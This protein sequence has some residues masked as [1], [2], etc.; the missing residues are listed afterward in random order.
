M[1]FKPPKDNSAEIARR[2]EAQRQAAIT[3]GRQKID[4]AFSQ[5]ND[6][7]YQGVQDA[8]LGYYQP[9]LEDQYAK[10]RRQLTLALSRSGNLNAS[11][12]ARQIGDLTK[13][14]EQNRAL[15][16]NQAL[17]AGQKA[18]ADVASNKSELYSQLSASADPAAAAATAIARADALS[19]PASY[20]PLGDLFASFVNTAAQGVAAEKAGYPGFNTGIFSPKSTVKVVN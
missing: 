11:A 5:F 6:P 3:E 4:T 15:I 1:C 19:Q 16:G 14:Y 10:A 2:Q 13:A 7:Y 17:Q 9:Q 12:G 18:R 20:S 8:Y